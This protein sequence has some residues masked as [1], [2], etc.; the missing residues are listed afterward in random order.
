MKRIAIVILVISLLSACA[1][2]SFA[3]LVNGGTGS[4]ADST[5][6]FDGI[7]VIKPET[8][9]NN[10]N[11]GTDTDT[12]TGTDTDTNTGTDTDNNTGTDTDTNTGTDSDN[13][14][15]T[16]TDTN[17]GTDTDNN[18]GTDTDT[19]TG[20]DTD[21]N[22]GTDTDTNTGTDT[23]TN[24]GTDTDTN[25]GTNTDNNTG[26]GT[27]Y[28][29][30]P[31]P[32]TVIKPVVTP[33]APA[34]PQPEAIKFEYDDVKESDWF[35]E[36]VE[37]VSGNKLMMGTGEKTFAPTASVTRAMAIT[38]IYRIAKEP[39]A[40]GNAFSDV[41][42]SSWYGN[43]VAWGAENK[44]VNG[45]G[46]NKF[47][48]NADITREQ[49]AVMLYNYGKTI[50]KIGLSADISSYSDSSKVS[51]WAEDAMKWAVANGIING[52]TATTLAPGD[53][54]TRAE[55]AAVLKRFVELTK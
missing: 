35:Y 5:I 19:N 48:P 3:A 12:N 29:P 13:N 50:G 14:T 28:T 51:S 39:S 34:T 52:K 25:T 42:H 9:D 36:Y 22:T 49:M 11:T 47:S 16:D 15:G 1:V 7:P 4:V 21:T 55:T 46:D 2:S 8:P 17:T 44:I 33:D 30:I 53:K 37:Y 43:A 20:T 38:V 23:D 32:G 27:G 18:T 45:V 26:T 10:E 31:F 54:I 40:S 6:V 24:T 41:D